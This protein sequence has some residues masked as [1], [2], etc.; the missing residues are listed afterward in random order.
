MRQIGDL[1]IWVGMIVLAVGVVYYTPV[2]AEYATS[3]SKP[4]IVPVPGAAR[5]HHT[6]TFAPPPPYGERHVSR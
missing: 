5:R 1:A 6:P 2:V 4:Q 3:E